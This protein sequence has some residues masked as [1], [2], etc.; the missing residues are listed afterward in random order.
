[1]RLGRA[2]GASS[3]V[4]VAYVMVGDPTVEASIDVAAACV[5][6]GASVI[7]LGVPFSDPIADG[8]V[9]AAAGARALARGVR[10]AHVLDA[11]AELRRRVD[12]PIVLMGY[13]NPLLR[14]GADGLAERVARAGADAVLVPDL[15]FDH[16]D[17]ARAA[18][19]ARG[20]ALPHL[21]APT[22]TPERARRIT[23]AATG[24]VYLVGVTGVTGAGAPDPAAIRAQIASL[25]VHARTPIVTGF[26]VRSPAQV[27]SLAHPR[28]G[29]PD[30][31]VV[32]SAIVELAASRAD[33][34]D[35]L[36][37]VKHLVSALSGALAPQS[38]KK[39]P[40]PC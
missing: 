38:S 9:I 1:M 8:P 10:V 24:F 20:V 16:A 19:T 33:A 37:A 2:L 15:P 39:E 32:G 22:T 30:G 34:A 13:A 31:I 21:V 7:E 23:D 5:H 28:D 35:R 17:G 12:A 26:G 11:A 25:R 18:L 36:A 3:P 4:L 14:L 6:A 27:A 29:A 40:S